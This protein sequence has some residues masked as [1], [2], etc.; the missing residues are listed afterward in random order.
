MNKYLFLLLLPVIA[1][2]QWLNSTHDDTVRITRNTNATA[3]ASGDIIRSTATAFYAVNVSRIGNGPA[4]GYITSVK[5]VIDTA[6]TSGANFTVRFFSF[7]DTAGRNVA[8]AVD[9]AAYQDN[10]LTSA[11]WVDDVNLSLSVSGASATAANGSTAAMGS[12]NNL[13]IPYEVSTGGRLWMVVIAKGAYT[14]PFAG[15]IRLHVAVERTY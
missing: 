15:N 1:S 11:F 3:Y 4:R 10:F 8:A 12:A 13:N 6:N 7:P 9:N 5:M 14:P 2:G